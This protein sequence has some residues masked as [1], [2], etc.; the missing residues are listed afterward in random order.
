MISR[1]KIEATEAEEAVT[2][3]AT[4][5]AI[6]TIEVDLIEMKIS[7]DA[8]ITIKM[9]MRDRKTWLMLRNRL[10]SSLLKDHRCSLALSQRLRKRNIKSSISQ[11]CRRD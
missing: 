9:G 4:G 10:A 3:V 7:T 2:E 6:R 1:A 8:V 11:I 5:P